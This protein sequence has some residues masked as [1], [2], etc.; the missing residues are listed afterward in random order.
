M[1]RYNALYSR[2][3]P[4]PTFKLDVYNL[5]LLGVMPEFQGKGIGSKLVR[6][7]LERARRQHTAVCLD[8]YT[9][10]D[11]AHYLHWGFQFRGSEIMT[12]AWQDFMMT[13]LVWEP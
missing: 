12:S 11:V 2:S 13:V 7:G 3:L 4:T 10:K 1:P 5:T 9:D 8:T 6:E